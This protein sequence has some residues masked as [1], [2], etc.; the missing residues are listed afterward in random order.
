MFLI[1]NAWFPFILENGCS[2][3]V[4]VIYSLRGVIRFDGFKRVW[5][6]TYLRPEEIFFRIS[7]FPNG[8]LN[9]VGSGCV[10]GS[11][12]D[13]AVDVLSTFTSKI[14]LRGFPGGSVVKNPPA[15][16]EDTGLIPG[17]GRSH[18]PSNNLAHALQLLSL[19]STAWEPHYWAHM[20]LL[21]K[22]TNPRDHALQQEKPV[23]CNQR[24][25]LLSENREKTWAEVKTQH[26]HE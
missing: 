24:G 25:A 20:L 4:V 11:R 12:G 6:Q 15:N 8:Q 16:A 17:P 1:Q 10:V 5:F 2:S 9:L 26:S 14:Q 19:G 18:V 13:S 23:H 3:C 7:Y 21:L 22:L